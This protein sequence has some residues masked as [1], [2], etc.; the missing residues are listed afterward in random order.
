MSEE[1]KPENKPFEAGQEILF[2][3]LTLLL[4]IVLTLVFVLGGRQD[5]LKSDENYLVAN[6]TV[7]D[8]LRKDKSISLAYTFKAGEPEKVYIEEDETVPTHL[9]WSVRI[10]SLINIA[11]R[12][13][14]PEVHKIESELLNDRK[15]GWIMLLSCQ[16]IG[17][18]LLGASIC[19]I[20]SGCWRKWRGDEV[21]LNHGYGKFLKHFKT[22]MLYILGLGVTIF[23]VWFYLIDHVRILII[24]KVLC[25]FAIA[26]I[27]FKWFGFPVLSWFSRII[28]NRSMKNYIAPLI[29]PDKRKEA[30]N[31][32]SYEL[33]VKEDP[34]KYSQRGSYYLIDLDFKKARQDVEKA[35]ELDPD[36]ANYYSLLLAILYES[37]DYDE[38]LRISRILEERYPLTWATCRFEIFIHLGR[39]ETEEARASLDRIKIIWKEESGKKEP[40]KNFVKERYKMDL[41]MDEALVLIAEGKSELAYS[42]LPETFDDAYFQRRSSEPLYAPVFSMYD[43][44]GRKLALDS[45]K[46]KD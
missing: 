44:Q 31:K 6:G 36:N 9:Y 21:V 46:E 32:L 24:L 14:N 40:H 30:I 16:I 8:E 37:K 42:I 10:G 38:A 19:F 5:K 12:P 43:D 28:L 17:V 4:L 23:F 34:A 33:T 3:C 39:N 41:I 2:G 20:F 45:V 35:I 27:L 15:Y 29:D 22:I 26:F 25:Y 7:T 13:S 18:S 1:L 11:Y